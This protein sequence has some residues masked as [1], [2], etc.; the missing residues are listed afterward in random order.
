VSRGAASGVSSPGAFQV[1]PPRR[2]VHALHGPQRLGAPLWP[3]PYQHAAGS[4]RA[5]RA[6]A[7]AEAGGPATERWEHGILVE[8]RDRGR[9]DALA[10]EWGESRVADARIGDV[11]AAAP[12]ADDVAALARLEARGWVRPLVRAFEHVGAKAA[13]VGGMEA[14]LGAEHGPLLAA[15][16]DARSRPR[17]A[18]LE[19]WLAQSAPA[20]GGAVDPE[21]TAWG[22][23]DAP[24]T[25]PP[26]RG[27]WIA[28]ERL[29]RALDA[30]A[31]GRSWFLE[32]VPAHCRALWPLRNL[33]RLADRRGSAL[34]EMRFSDFE[35]LEAFAPELPVLCL[36]REI[37]GGGFDH[38]LFHR[39]CPMPRTGDRRADEWGLLAV[40][41]AAQA[42]NGLVFDGRHTG[43]AYDGHARWR[44]Y[45][46]V[47]A[48]ERDFGLATLAEQLAAF[49]ILGL[50]CH[51][52]FDGDAA[53]TWAALVPHGLSR[54]AAQ[55]FIERYGRYVRLDAAWVDGL[56]ARYDTPAFNAFG[57]LLADRFA[58]SLAETFAAVDAM[59]TDAEDIDLRTSDIAATGWAA[60]GAENARWMAQ[61]TAELQHLLQRQAA[62]DLATR[63]G[64]DTIA[65]IARALRAEL[66]ALR[67][68]A[69]RASEGRPNAIADLGGLDRRAGTLGA[70]LRQ[71]EHRF[72][73]AAGSIRAAQADG[74][75]GPSVPE[76]FR[77]AIRELFHGVD[78]A[79]PPHVGADPPPGSAS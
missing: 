42:Y 50:V 9:R 60:E 20:W 5:A 68:E 26:W 37:Y 21:V 45:A 69:A 31:G 4:E 64:L 49:R 74:L 54:A 12:G 18:L 34:A 28:M 55:R 43:P 72:D 57:E 51:P 70:E 48:L 19:G 33:M 41:A 46:L 29:D 8:V 32:R 62:P 44:G 14:D 13:W 36:D 6:W 7:G 78:C 38:D 63:L 27:A 16:R 24:E 1:S 75:G 25:P 2:T 66:A 40:E 67:D 30:F 39:L 65:H 35:A 47:E 52:R 23:G 3:E 71:L 10:A 59:V 15:V 58:P 11:N 53:A 22:L 61:K 77:T 17:L 79:P 73:R 56:H 76:D